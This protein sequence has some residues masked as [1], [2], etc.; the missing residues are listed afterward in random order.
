MHHIPNH[1]DVVVIGAGVAGLSAAYFLAKAGVQTTIIDG[2]TAPKGASA[3]AIGIP[4]L[5][6]LDT[7][8]RLEQALGPTRTEILLSLCRENFALA[9]TLVPTTP[10]TWIWAN[11][12]DMLA[13]EWTK[14]CA[15]LTKNQIEAAPFSS[16]ENTLHGIQLPDQYLVEPKQGLCALEEKC[17]L[18]NA[19]LHR[20]VSATDVALTSGGTVLTT[21]HGP[22]TADAVIFATGAWTGLLL[23]GFQDKI[24]PVRE[25]VQTGTWQ[26]PGPKTCI[27]AQ[28]G[29]VHWRSESTRWWISGARW[30]TPHFEIGETEDTNTPHAISEALNQV[31]SQLNPSPID[32]VETWSYLW[33][34]TCDGLPILGPVPGRST[35]ISCTGFM[36]NDW[37][38]GIRAG[39]AVADGLLSGTA[40]GIPEWLTAT[41]FL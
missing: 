3:R 27:R 39:K 32:R 7:P 40:P 9:Q 4:W 14:S 19:T 35:W 31:R 29:Y 38:F 28:N 11:S 34:K 25:H 17:R 20:G 23:D 33:A 37:G 13:N 12:G 26:S 21:N 16:N 24:V 15:I 10:T 22:L 36:G 6:F 18:H 30:A 1:S 2:S 8:W 5:G 41:R